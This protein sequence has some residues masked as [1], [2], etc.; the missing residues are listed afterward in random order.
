M[1]PASRCGLVLAA[2]I[3]GAPLAAGEEALDGDGPG[4]LRLTRDA[5]LDAMP[6]WTPDGRRIVF[7]SRRAPEKAGLLP[8]RKIWRIDADGGGATKLTDGNAD[9]YHPV[10]SPDGTKI[11]FVSEAAGT[12]DVWLMAADGS[13]PIPLTD[14][15]GIEQ[16]P[17]WSPDGHRIAYAALPREGGNLDLWIMNDDGSGKRKLTFSAANEIFPAWRPDGGSIAFTSDAG[18]NFGIFGVDLQGERTFPIVDGAEHETRPAWSP[19][20]TKIA[21]TRWPADGVAREAGIWVANA[22]GSAA[23]ELP[24][25]RPSVHPAWSPDGATLAFQR[26]TGG[27]SDVWSVRLPGQVARSGRLH[28]A[29]ALRGGPAQDMVRLRNGETFRG[30]VRDRRFRLRTSYGELAFPTEVIASIR[31]AGLETGT[32]RVIL[33]NGDSLSGLLA[34]DEVAFTAAEGSL[35]LRKEEIEAIGFR[36]RKESGEEAAP[37]RFA[38]KNGDAFSG[39]VRSARLRMRI[40]GQSLELPF[41]ELSRIEFGEVGEKSRVITRKG[42]TLTGT[43]ENPL[44]EIELALG[45]RLA[46]HPSQ[47]RAL[48]LGEDRP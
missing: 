32:A 18:G 45:P 26:E 44:V 8:T 39:S 48:T 33:V 3:L 36:L 7:H 11:A 35:T 22:D 2:V 28:L 34:G 10:V 4:A 29:Q 31:F 37:A 14:D 43:V 46:L 23:V 47:V 6:S 16:H 41:G 30:A 9:E 42:D 15:P 38:M 25:R 21:F 17:A 13:N 12:R 20:G 27:N 24:L 19:D 5:G 40:G 1:A